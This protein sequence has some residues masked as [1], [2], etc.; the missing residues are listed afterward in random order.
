MSRD[1]A[2]VTVSPRTT[3]A[4]ARDG[5]MPTN[6]VETPLHSSVTLGPGDI[7]A[8]LT[9]MPDRDAAVRW[10]HH[11]EP[12]RHVYDSADTDL[13]FR[14]NFD[15]QASATDSDLFL[16]LFPPKAIKTVFFFGLFHQEAMQCGIL[17]LVVS[18]ERGNSRRIEHRRPRLSDTRYVVYAPCTLL[19]P[20]YGATVLSDRSRFVSPDYV[21]ERARV[22][23]GVW[24]RFVTKWAIVTPNPGRGSGPKSGLAGVRQGG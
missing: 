16:G 11:P 22:D 21:S 18:V 3:I 23:G 10:A 17:F 2:E 13:E 20:G 9:G 5:R 15:C 4:A 7:Q 6:D 8:V 12:R 1:K 14:A 19:A 24:Q